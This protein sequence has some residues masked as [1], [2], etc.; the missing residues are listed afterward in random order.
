M[1]RG[2]YIKRLSP[3]L[4]FSLY[5][6]A[7]QES[8]KQSYLPN[9]GQ[10]LEGCFQPS[11]RALCRQGR[12]RTESLQLRLWNLNSTSNSPV[13]PRRLSCQICANQY[14]AEMSGNVNN[15]QKT[16]TKRNDVIT[17]VI[18]ANLHFTST[19]S[20][21]IVKFQRRNSHLSFLFP[22]RLQSAPESLL[23]GYF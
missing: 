9:K 12:K 20:M 16:H 4:E 17:N 5:F 11:L 19:F 8:Q 2:K 15:T 7:C 22:H 3:K 18:S 21:Q 23:A 14:K 13:A 1:E 10:E 6:Y